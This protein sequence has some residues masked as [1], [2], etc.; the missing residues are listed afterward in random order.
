MW[1]IDLGEI[2]KLEQ[3]K[4]EHTSNPEWIQIRKESNKYSNVWPNPVANHTSVVY[5]DKMYMFG[6]SSGMC[7]NEDFYSFDLNQ[8][9]WTKINAKP[10][11]SDESHIC[12]SR[13][14]HS[15]VILHDQMVVFGGFSQ[16]TRTNNIFKYHI[17]T[18]EWELVKVS[19]RKMPCE[20]AG[21]SAVVRYDEQNG[22]CMYIFGGKDDEN[23]KLSDLWCFNFKS[24]QW[25]QLPE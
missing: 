3:G 11:N 9:A 4:S 7:E 20:R 25:E 24:N 14:E 18:N 6:G 5:K 2:G 16:G 13:D 8:N 17:N 22:D 1:C 21:H 15:A 12:N 19:G 23:N 10:K